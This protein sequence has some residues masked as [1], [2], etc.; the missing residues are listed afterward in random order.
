MKFEFKVKKGI[1]EDFNLSKLKSTEIKIK[2]LVLFTQGSRTKNNL[3][4]GLRWKCFY[5]GEL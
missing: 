3:N 4:V 5:G 2:E 1:E